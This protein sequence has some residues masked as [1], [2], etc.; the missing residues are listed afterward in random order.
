VNKLYKIRK[1][2]KLIMTTA[3]M[4]K[5]LLKPGASV[6]FFMI[7]TSA[8]QKEMITNVAIVLLSVIPGLPPYRFYF[9]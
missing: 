2:E 6:S 8:K 5:P 7:S 1:N 9:F 4:A 3:M